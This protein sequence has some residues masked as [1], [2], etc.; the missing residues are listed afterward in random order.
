MIAHDRQQRAAISRVEQ[1]AT[2]TAGRTLIADERIDTEHRE[3]LIV[4]GDG[5]AFRSPALLAQDQFTGIGDAEAIEQVLRL[6]LPDLVAGA[7]GVGF[8]QCVAVRQQRLAFVAGE[9]ETL[10]SV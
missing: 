1:H 3:P 9:V 2:D 7:Q 10:E 8:K 6:S 5:T 4:H